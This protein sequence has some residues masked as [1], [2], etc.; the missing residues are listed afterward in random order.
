MTVFERKVKALQLNLPLLVLKS[1][2]RSVLKL[3]QSLNTLFDSPDT[4]YF[5]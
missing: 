2:F 4:L 5:L 3:Q 1:P